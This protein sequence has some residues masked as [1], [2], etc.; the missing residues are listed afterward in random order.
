MSATAPLDLGK[1]IEAEQIKKRELDDAQEK[2]NKCNSDLESYKAEIKQNMRDDKQPN[3]DTRNKLQ[4]LMTNV[5][6]GEFALENAKAR[7]IRARNTAAGVKA[8]DAQAL[9]R[10][11]GAGVSPMGMSPVGPGALPKLEVSGTGTMAPSA[12]RSPSPPRGCFG[13]LCG[14][15]NKSKSETAGGR[16]SRIR[17]L[18][19]KRT[20]KKR[21][22]SRK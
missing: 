16:K 11:T 13:R 15:S 4:I 6:A 20:Y 21:R 19:T 18:K 9:Q 12:Q 22:T 17:K 5:R 3:E 7:Y 8:A 2:L 14:K 1:Y 10:D